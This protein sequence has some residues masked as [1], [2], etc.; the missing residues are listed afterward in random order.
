MTT[1]YVYLH[2]FASSPQ[3]KKAQ[4][5][6]EA[7]AARGHE[8]VVPDLNLPSFDRLSV[9]EMRVALRRLDD[10]LGA[11]RYRIVGSS[12]GG[13]LLVDAAS[14]LGSRLERAVLLATPRELAALWSRWMSPTTRETWQSRGAI[15]LP[16]ARGK[17]TRVHYG[18]YEEVERIGAAPLP[19]LTVPTL[20]VHGARDGLVPVEEA[21]AY[22]AATGAP[23]EVF[24]D[25]HELHA[26][27]EPLVARVVPFLLA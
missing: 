8:L 20:F 18:F 21:R 3:A 15:P 1:R 12:L 26:S 19:T 5:L 9:G 14:W 23:I 11:P 2:G 17:M 6:A 7:L 25:E 16:D 22:A 4:A 24:D 13:W 10:E 27:I